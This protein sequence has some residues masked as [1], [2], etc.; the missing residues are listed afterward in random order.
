MRD[1]KSERKKLK[2]LSRNE[3]CDLILTLRTHLEIK[4]ELLA[5][6]HHSNSP[7]SDGSKE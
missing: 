2:K 6:R 5:K 3:L 4:D 1:F 7:P